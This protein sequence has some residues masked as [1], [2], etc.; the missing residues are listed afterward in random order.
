MY[1]CDFKDKYYH[2]MYHI[3]CKECGWE[4]DAKEYAIKR[5]SQV[6]K[7]VD[8]AGRYHHYLP[9]GSWKSKR[10][11]EIYRK[12]K[13]RC[14]NRNDKSYVY[15]GA[16]GIGICEQWLINPLLFEEWSLTHGYTDTASIDRID[17][18][19]SYSP[20]NC[21]WIYPEDNSRYK[22]TTRMI[23]IDIGV[24]HSGKDWAK[25]LGIGTNAI[26]RMMREYPEE[27]VKE[28]IGERLK[29]NTIHRKPNQSWMDAYGIV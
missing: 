3:K 10:I 1:E 28:F 23:D 17:S 4:H 8:A 2:R 29:D 13:E 20:D 27:K 21:R 11:R 19:L 6:C 9:N 25:I 15:Y 22:S 12:M 14:Y 26:N 16:K 7:H 5:L 24:S 18:Q